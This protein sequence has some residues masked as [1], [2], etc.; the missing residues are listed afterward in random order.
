V[1]GSILITEAVERSN[2]AELD[3][4]APGV[5]RLLFESKPGPDVLADVEVVYFS[6]DLFPDRMRP[7]VMALREMRRLGWMHSFSAG[8][9]GAF[10]AK[11]LE[12]GA[13]LTTSSGAQAVPIAHT[14]VLYLLALSRGLPQWLDAQKHHS[15][16]PRPVRDLQD[17]V[18]GVVGLGPIGREV[19]RLGQ[20]LGMEVVGVR[21]QPRGDEGFETV[22]QDA[23]PA[24]LPR[25]DALVLAVPLTDETQRLIDAAALAAMKP[26]ALLVNVGRGALV[27]EQALCAALAAG[28]LGGAGLD[29]FEVEPLPESSP[30]WELENVIIT[31]H[32]SGTSAGNHHRATQIFLE[33]LGCYARGEPMRNEVSG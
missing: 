3:R 15:W 30:L 10:F 27:D 4:A 25:L 29:V 19:A 9:D 31:P 21:R 22:S 28:R 23:L 14:V 13:R 7:F 24:L 17:M 11:T 18:L 6:E 33:N 5:P 1:R 20:A 2:A 26:D 12:R 8:V 32:S 16:Q